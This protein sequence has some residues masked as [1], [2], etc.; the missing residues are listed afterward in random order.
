MREYNCYESFQENSG[1]F[2]DHKLPEH[3]SQLFKNRL[4]RKT[5]AAVAIALLGT[6][7]LS[8]TSV[9]SCETTSEF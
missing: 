4:R 7:S 8:V 2:C 6:S 3:D 1:F 9:A 5:A